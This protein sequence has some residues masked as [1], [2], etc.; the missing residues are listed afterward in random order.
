MNPKYFSALIYILIY[1]N[2]YSQEIPQWA[3][4]LY[5]EDSN[6]QVDSVTVGYD[7]SAE[8]WDAF[9]INFEEYTWIDT[10]KFDVVVNR[11]GT[12][13]PITGDYNADSAKQIEISSTY[14]FG[15]TLN[16]INGKMPITMTWDM[17]LFYSS[18]LPFPNISPLPNGVAYVYCGSAEPGYINCPSAFDDDPL[19]IT[20]QPNINYIY[21]I[22]S[23]HLFDG[24]GEFPYENPETALGAQFQL[25]FTPYDTHTLIL[26][27]NGKPE[28]K[29]FP[30]PFQDFLYI[31]S[32]ETITD[33]YIINYLGE[34][35]YFSN[36]SFNGTKILLPS[37]PSGIY[38]VILKS[39]SNVIS[40]PI[41]K[42]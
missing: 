9:D 19:T 29:I 24:S 2:L 6:G 41:I 20:D 32:T 5:F 42:I 13:S 21:P 28:I 11:Y 10:A 22:E 35:I 8:A 31:N 39:D 34:V 7:P 37:I 27:Q 30:N 25:L 12:Y 33:F 26:E 16:F 15:A 36:T 4:A 3:I 38:T 17:S 1:S 18:E 40:S 14:N 23:P